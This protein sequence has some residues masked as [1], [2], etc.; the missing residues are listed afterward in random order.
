MKDLYFT[1]RPDHYYQRIRP[2]RKAVT[3]I[4]FSDIVVYMWNNRIWNDKNTKPN[5]NGI[6]W[7]MINYITKYLYISFRIADSEKR[8]PFVF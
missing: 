5:L 7:V 6:K 4:F 3:V 1:Q 8:D 2:T